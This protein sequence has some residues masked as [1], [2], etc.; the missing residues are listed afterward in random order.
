MTRYCRTYVQTGDS[1]WEKKYWEVLD[2]R[3][4][5]KPRPDGRTISL[6]DS[7]KKLGFTEAELTKL[8]IAEQNSNDLVW[9]EKVAFNAMKGL[10]ADSLREFTIKSKPD[11][12]FASKILFDENYHRYKSL[13]MKPIDECIQ[14]VMNRTQYKVK[15]ETHLN[16]VLLYTIISFII[17][18]SI[19]SIVSYFLI[20]NRIILQLEELNK[21]RNRAELSEI[22]FKTLFEKSPDKIIITS[23]EGDFIDCNKSALEFE[24]LNSL[25][26]L[27]TYKS[28]QTYANP[29][30]RS[31]F[32]EQIQIKGYI[33]IAQSCRC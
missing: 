25:K 28:Y 14:M 8:K 13:I 6:Q 30:E 1:I 32:V 27:Q 17:I 29:E 23:L 4:G 26:E 2:I 33:K 5:I 9:T 31:S 10:Y 24:N 3:N 7:M 19:I 16:F 22:K 12:A 21:E 15:R 20:R 11:T 18:I